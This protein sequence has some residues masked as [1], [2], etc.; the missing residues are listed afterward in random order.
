MQGVLPRDVLDRL[1]THIDRCAD[2]LAAVAALGRVGAAAGSGPLTAE[3]YIVG[4][5]IARGGMGQVFAGTDRVLDRPVAIK[6]VRDPIGAAR[7]QP[8]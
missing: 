1:D 4:D 2:C 5:E 6:T 8:S 7:F 3:R